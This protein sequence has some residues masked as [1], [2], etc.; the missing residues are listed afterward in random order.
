MAKS[1]NCIG[2]NVQPQDKDGMTHHTIA[3]GQ[4]RHIL[5][6]AR[7]R[8]VDL[9][10]VLERAGVS[11]VLLHSPLSRV[12][13]SQF[14]VIMRVLRRTL[15][16]DY[17]G[18]LSRPLPLG[19]FEQVCRLIISAPTLGVA[20]RQGLRVYHGVIADFT[21][22][23]RVKD[24]M[25]SVVL[26]S[27]GPL[28]PYLWYGQR[29]FLFLTSGLSSWLAARRIPIARVD[30]RCEIPSEDAHRLFHSA[31]HYGQATTAMHFDA[32]WLDLPVVQNAQTL[33]DFLKSA[34]FDLLVK[35]Q[36]RASLTDRIRRMLR[37]HLAGE[38]PSLEVVSE[39]LTL[40][41][42]TLRR[43]LRDEGQGYQALKDD[44]RRDV[45]I[46][47]LARA[48]MTLVCIAERLGFS[49]PSTFHRAFKKWTGVAPGEYRRT[50]L[51]LTSL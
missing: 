42:Q 43:R 6:G 39:A 41:P 18:L 22:R 19:T 44:L 21:P 7:H 9:D 3:I 46:E 10:A 25:A 38:L 50:R 11:P 12:S 14:A 51:G 40:T 49:E 31:I 15:Q 23:L 2:G 45:A 26:D 32:K 8:G 20:L 5:E 13:Q 28:D 1:F 16:D 37:Q 36:D 33:E 29:T 4:V 27:R 30:Y 35:Y 17:L 47:Y 24:G 34:P 48:D